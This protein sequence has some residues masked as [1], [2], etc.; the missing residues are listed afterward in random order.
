[1]KKE[2]KDFLESNENEG[3]KH[4]KLWKIMK[5]VLREKFMA[6]FASKINWREHTLAA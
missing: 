2:I 5:V 6:L 3:T 1:M 4:K